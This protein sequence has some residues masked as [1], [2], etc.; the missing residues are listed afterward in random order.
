MQ[1]MVQNCRREDLRH[2]PV[3]KLFE[4]QQCSNHFEDYQ[5]MNK[6]TKSKLI[7]NA[8]PTM[9]DVANPHAKVTPSRLVK[10]DQLL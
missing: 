2:I 10:K 4:Y 6:E 9:F 5:F 7:W 1:K 8:V 3:K